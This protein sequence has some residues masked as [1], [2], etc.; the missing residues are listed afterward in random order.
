MSPVARPVMSAVNLK[1]LEPVNRR[2]KRRE[3][4]EEKKQRKTK[5]DIWQCINNNFFKFNFGNVAGNEQ[6]QTDGRRDL[7]NG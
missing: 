2:K 1:S 6:V 7:A 3:E 4:D 5:S